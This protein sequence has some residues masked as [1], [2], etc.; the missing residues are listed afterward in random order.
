MASFARTYSGSSLNREPSVAEFTA[1]G[2][3][4]SECGRVTAV[5]AALEVSRLTANRSQQVD[6]HVFVEDMTNAWRGT[7]DW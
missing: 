6:C 7:L 2:A 4:V 1:A 3:N 5:P